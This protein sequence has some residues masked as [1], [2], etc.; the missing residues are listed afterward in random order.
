[1][2]KDVIEIHFLDGTSKRF[3]NCNYEGIVVGMGI[4][5]TSNI[6]FS[7]PKMIIPINAIKYIE[8]IK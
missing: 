1:M 3:E 7:N 8:L 4:Q 6:T 2:L 5:G